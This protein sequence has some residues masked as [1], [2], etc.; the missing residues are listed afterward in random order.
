MLITVAEL[1]EYAR[2]AEKLLSESERRDVIDYLA[3]RPK[4]GADAGYWRYP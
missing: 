3:S 1:P 4:G 2:K